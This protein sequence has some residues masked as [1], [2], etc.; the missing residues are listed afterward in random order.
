M[1][2]EVL[3]RQSRTLIEP[4][5]KVYDNYYSRAEKVSDLMGAEPREIMEWVD[6]EIGRMM[7]SGTLDQEAASLPPELAEVFQT[8]LLKRT[9]EENQGEYMARSYQAFFD[10]EYAQRRFREIKDLKSRSTLEDLAPEEVKLVETYDLMMESVMRG[11]DGGL[12]PH[13]QGPGG[14]LKAE[15]KL[16]NMMDRSTA[17]PFRSGRGKIP[18]TEWGELKRR[19][20]TD[21]EPDVWIR[22]LLG[23]DEDPFNGLMRS[24]RKITSDQEAYTFKKQLAQTLVERGEASSELIPGRFDYK[25]DGLQEAGVP[26][27]YMADPKKAAELGQA[28]DSMAGGTFDALNYLSKTMA[29]VLNPVTHG[30]NIIANPAFLTMNGINPMS[31]LKP[32]NIRESRQ[33]LRMLDQD[34]SKALAKMSRA[35]LD[36]FKEGSILMMERGLME[37]VDVSDLNRFLDDIRRRSALTGKTTLGEL[38]GNATN[39]VTRSKL[40]GD[41]GKKYA[42]EDFFFKNMGYQLEKRRLGR[43]GAFNDDEIRELTLD[44][45]E[46]MLPTYSKRSKITEKFRRAQV[47][48]PFV[49]FY[50]EL[51]RTAKQTFQKGMQQFFDPEAYLTG[52]LGQRAFT[53]QQVSA[54]RKL[55][56][57]RLAGI[58]ATMAAPFALQKMSQVWNGVSAEEDQAARSFMPP[59]SKDNPVFYYNYNNGEFDYVDLGHIFPHAALIKPGELAEPFT[60][61]TIPISEA[62]EA[63]NDLTRVSELS[64]TKKA[65][66][67]AK[68]GFRAFAPG[69]LKWGERIAKGASGLTNQDSMMQQYFP[70]KNRYGKEYEL[71]KELMSPLGRP[72]RQNVVDGL[73]WKARGYARADR[74]AKDIVN[75]SRNQGTNN[76]LNSI[77]T[78]RGE[79]RQSAEDL[80]KYVEDARTLGSS[81]EEIRSMMMGLDTIPRADVE[82]LLRGI[83]P[84]FRQPSWSR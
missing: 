66:I 49:N 47:I 11:K 19:S 3:D 35:E 27:V 32:G 58:S 51:V 34:P 6:D 52:V 25:V 29:T 62:F 39:K 56:A 70:N 72:T 30:R 24:I 7:K 48:A 50:S 46:T 5:G 22:T 38:V 21:K 10:P 71:T 23:E 67:I 81:E 2:R 73:K 43:T 28:A 84:T 17:S 14:E 13:Y 53:D 37:N 9:I 78:A 57:K 4:G 80:I 69:F 76:I 82:L 79:H 77:E 41:P 74:Q 63:Y 60:S 18:A 31:V 36:E 68:R 20:L 42:Y 54:I 65:E 16:F 83:I 12:L 64:P 15:R 75:Q 45:L 1:A 55:G 40:L 59:W 26:P 44:S 61:P 8:G 33:M